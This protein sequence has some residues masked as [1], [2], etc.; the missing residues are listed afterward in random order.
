NSLGT[1]YSRSVDEE[2]VS[3]TVPAS[4]CIAHNEG[5]SPQ[6]RWFMTYAHE[7]AGKRPVVHSEGK[8]DTYRAD[9]HG[10]SVATKCY[11]QGTVVALGQ[12]EKCP[13]CHA[14]F[15]WLP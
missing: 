13:C 12:L 6:T 11:G 2:S 7:P 5:A 4:M 14:S 8:W 9:I 15:C 1:I 10:F 3:S